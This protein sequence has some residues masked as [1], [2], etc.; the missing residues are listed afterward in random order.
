MAF[1]IK[2]QAKAENEYLG[3]FYW[4]EGQQEGLGSRFEEAIEKQLS[5]IVNNPESYP[6]KKYHARESK[7]EDFPYLVVYKFYPGKK[8]I[9]VLS[10]FHTSRK[11]S[12]KYR[13]L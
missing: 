12:K 7:V 3:A 13:R 11:P 4:Y 1:T 2:F 10:I 5:R 6:L 9:L 8:L